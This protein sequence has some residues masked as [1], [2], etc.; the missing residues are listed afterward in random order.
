MRVTDQVTNQVAADTKIAVNANSLANSSTGPTGNALLDELNKSDAN[1]ASAVTK[2]KYEEIK[3]SADTLLES[4]QIFL[5]EGNGSLL[6]ALDTEEG[7]KQLKEQIAQLVSGYNNV[8]NKLKTSSN[9]LD[10][11]YLQMLKEVAGDYAPELA[12]LGITV[13]AQGKLQY[14][15]SKTAADADTVR[16]TLGAQSE[17]MQKLAFISEHISDNARAGIKNLGNTY[18]S[19]GAASASSVLAGSFD[20]RS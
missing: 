6:S 12:K 13:S 4:A 19:Y 20:F 8:G 1:K 14:D 3:K 9:S 15:S 17:F 7:R 16:N 10:A 18:N 11:Y 2:N 5:E